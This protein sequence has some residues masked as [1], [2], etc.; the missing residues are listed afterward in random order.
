[1]INVVRNETELLEIEIPGDETLTHLLSRYCE[2]DSAAVRD[3]PFL[4]EP[5]IIVYG[6]NPVKELTKA[7]ENIISDLEEFAELFKKEIQ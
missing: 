7:A 6:K 3:H 4:T 1:M 2:T 5:K